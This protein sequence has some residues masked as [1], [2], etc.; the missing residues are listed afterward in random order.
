MLVGDQESWWLYVWLEREG[1]GLPG[2]GETEMGR[3]CLVIDVR[4]GVGS[5]R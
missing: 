2:A 5:Y 1:I 3:W 4:E